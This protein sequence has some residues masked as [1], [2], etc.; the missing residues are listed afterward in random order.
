MIVKATKIEL[1]RTAAHNAFAHRGN[2]WRSINS[3]GSGRSARLV[4]A[5]RANVAEH[6]IE[7]RNAVGN[8]RRRGIEDNELGNGTGRRCAA[9]GAMLKVPVAALMMMMRGH[10]RRRGGAEFQQERRAAGRH[11][12]DRYIRSKQQYSQQQAGQEAASTMVR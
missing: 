6:G 12:A 1:I 8:H 2:Q 3:D 4:C 11:E 7:G 9:K 5:R 10:R